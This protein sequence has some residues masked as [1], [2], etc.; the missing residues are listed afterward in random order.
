VR[1]HRGRNVEAGHGCQHEVSSCRSAIYV[2]ADH[3]C[4]HEVSSCRSAIYVEADHGCQ[5]EVSSYT[6]STVFITV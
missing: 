6:V 4:Q 2:E 1:A 5:H 3:G